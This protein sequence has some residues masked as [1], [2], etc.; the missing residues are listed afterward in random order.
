MNPFLLEITGESIYEIKLEKSM[1]YGLTYL[2]RIGIQPRTDETIK[3]M[4]HGLGD[5]ATGRICS[6]LYSS[7]A[8]TAN[9]MLK[10]GH[11]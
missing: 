10:K 11:S 2:L 1:V 5:G 8:K 9:M 3:F 4:A 6:R 7:T